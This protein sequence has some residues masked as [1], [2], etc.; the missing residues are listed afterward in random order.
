[1]LMRGGDPLP[2]IFK[3]GQTIESLQRRTCGYAEINEAANFI[4]IRFR[5]TVEHRQAALLG[6]H[7]TA[8]LV[9]TIK[10]EGQESV[11]FSRAYTFWIKLNSFAA[12][13]L[14]EQVNRFLQIAAE[15]TANNGT[16]ALFVV[17]D[18]CVE[19]Q[20]DRAFTRMPS[21]AI[22]RT[23]SGDFF[24]QLID[25][26][27]KEVSEQSRSDFPCDTEC[28]QVACGSEPDREF[29][30]NG[31]RMNADGNFFTSPVHT[32]NSFTP[33]QRTDNFNIAQ[34]NGFTVCVILRRKNEI[35]Y[36]PAGSEGDTHAAAR[37]VVNYRP[38]FSRT[39]RI[40]Q[41]HNH[42][43]STDFHIPGDGSN[44][45]PRNG[46]IWIQTTESMEMA[47]G[48]PNC[49]EPMLVGKSRSLKE[50]TISILL[51]AII[52]CRKEKQ[53]EIKVLSSGA[54]CILSRDAWVEYHAVTP[55]QCPEKFQR[56][57]IKRDAG[58]CDPLLNFCGLPKGIGHR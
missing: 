3:A 21:L 10:T 20:D 12:R 54:P 22:S 29:R 51:S 44:R 52:G 57:N 39:Q 14:L 53:A 8:C 17:T 16:R 33:P 45:G 9:I 24:F 2:A 58:D 25:N 19:H 41:R 27:S 43:A 15:R 7:K 26:L 46:W 18:E 31:P 23:I 56:G 30:L 47:L 32:R 48:S 34:H 35:I 55:S 37:N 1:V 36:M 40:M 13:H 42:A 11:Q 6:P 5:N 49:M 28:L 50:K 4:N 38:F